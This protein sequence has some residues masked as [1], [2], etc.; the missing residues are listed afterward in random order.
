M[1]GV[2]FALG[3][4]VGIANLMVV[5]RLVAAFLE[6]LLKLVRGVRC[7]LPE[8]AKATTNRPLFQPPC[9]AATPSRYAA[10]LETP[11]TTLGIIATEKVPKGLHSIYQEGG[12]PP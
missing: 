9:K 12:H 10:Q 3:L 5:S 1:V 8:R 4:E 11:W 2:I 7:A 6:L